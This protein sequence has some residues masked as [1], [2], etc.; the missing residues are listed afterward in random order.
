MG[1]ASVDVV[2]PCGRCRQVIK[3]AQ[4]MAGRPLAILCAAPAGE[5]VKRFDLD[6]LLPEAF[7]PGNLGT[8]A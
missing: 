5:A 7:G 6:F 4:D 8:R 1:A 2:T 3:E